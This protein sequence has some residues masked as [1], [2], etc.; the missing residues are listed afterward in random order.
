M[1]SREGRKLF[2]ETRRLSHFHHYPDKYSQHY[3]DKNTS[4]PLIPNFK[5]GGSFFRSVRPFMPFFLLSFL[6]QSA[7]QQKNTNFLPLLTTTHYY[8]N[9]YSES[10]FGGLLLPLLSLPAS[11]EIKFKCITEKEVP[12]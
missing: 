2:Y 7:L 5:C 11:E 8:G 6:F 12:F 1:E 3:L 4:K 10:A 9:I